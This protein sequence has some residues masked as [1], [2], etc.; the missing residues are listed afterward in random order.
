M[1]IAAAQ[2]L[3]A[4]LLPRRGFHQGRAGKENRALLLHDHCLV[5]HGRH[6]GAA[7]RATAHH[8]GDLRDCLCR[9]VR[10]VE[11]DASEMLPIRENLRLMRQVGPAAID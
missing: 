11:K 9:H 7:R 3:G 5:R 2:V 10:L 8:A 4:D 6:I 1:Q